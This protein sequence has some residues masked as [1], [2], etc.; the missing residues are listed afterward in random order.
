MP[1]KNGTDGNTLGPRG[2]RRRG[3]PA[4]RLVPDLPLNFTGHPAASI[5]AGFADG[6]PVGMQIVGRRYADADVLA[7]SAAFERLRPWH[8][9]YAT[10]AP[11]L[12][13]VTGTGVPQ[14]VIAE[15]APQARGF[16]GRKR[17]R[18]ERRSRAR[19]RPCT[20]RA[21]A[22]GC[23]PPDLARWRGSCRSRQ[24]AAQVELPERVAYL[25]GLAQGADVPFADVLAVNALEEVFPERSRALLVALLAV[26]APGGVLLAH[27]EQWS[28]CELGNCAVVVERPDD[29][30]PWVVSPTVASCLPVVGVNEHGGAFGVGA[31]LAASDDRDGIPR[32]F[33]AREVLDA[34]DPID[35]LER[36]RLRG[37]A[38]GYGTVAAFPG[39]ADR[40]RRADR[41]ARRGRRRRRRAHEPLPARRARGARRRPE[42]DQPQPPRAPPAAARRAATRARAVR[43]DAPARLA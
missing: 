39:R 32:V 35:L 16:R 7:A 25:R 20:E 24:A 14:V 18:R 38:G 4:D 9:S 37:R 13:G 23:R 8:D 15:G 36:A 42:R 6:L 40:C 31:S 12:A 29:G 26:A 3:R 34:R 19:S 41:R 33:A 22:R 21:N 27:A 1:V 30:S 43:P 10:C 5:P 2:Q 11:A 28:A 17:A